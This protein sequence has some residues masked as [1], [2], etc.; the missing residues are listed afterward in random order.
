VG[1]PNF[2]KVFIGRVKRF[3]LVEMQ[4]YLQFM[5]AVDV[6]GGNILFIATIFT[7]GS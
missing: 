4:T 6:D 2:E 7:V 3:S 5:S 1:T